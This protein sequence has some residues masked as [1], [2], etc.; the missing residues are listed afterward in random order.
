[1]F[2]FVNCLIKG[3]QAIVS[4][5]LISGVFG[6][7]KIFEDDFSNQDEFNKDLLEKFLKEK[8]LNLSSEIQ[9]LKLLP[10]LKFFS[11]QKD[12][13]YE[14]NDKNYFFDCEGMIMLPGGIDPHVHFD[15]PGYD[16]REDFSTASA[17][18]IAGGITTIID[19]P[20]TSIPPVTT[21]KNFY[22]KLNV[23]EKL[24]YSDYGFF[25]G[26]SGKTIDEEDF[27]ENIYDLVDCNVKGFKAYLISGMDSFPRLTNYQLYKAANICKKF[28]K[29]L[30]IHAEDFEFIDGYYKENIKY[31]QQDKKK[32]WQKEIEFY[33]NSRST[34]AELLA[35][36]T[37][38]EIAK[39]TGVRLH[40]V[41]LSSGESVEFIEKER[42]NC[43]ITFETAPHYLEFT[44]DDFIRFGSLLKTAPA[45]KKQQ[46]KN[47][48]R[49]SI[50]NGS[51]SFV[52]SDHAACN[53]EEK[54]SGSFL[55]DYS[56]I[57]GVQTIY[58]YILSEFYDTLS[59]ERIIEI[60]SENA[61]KFYNLYPKKGVIKKGSDADFILVK[62]DERFVFDQNNLYSKMKFSP[63]HNFEF[64]HKIVATVLRARPAY[65]DGIGIKLQKGD[66]KYI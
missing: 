58:Q 8:S 64:K 56:G 7:I 46:D 3:K 5:D 51:C 26:I 6:E 54:R 45:V 60:M 55:K 35:I 62:K 66:G 40:I 19:M 33:I 41:H 42:K 9:D 50:K 32:D 63:F 38:C 48:L 24:S 44:E 65:Y 18:A 22:E 2:Y 1:M 52:A 16:F 25:G 34:L 49:E 30:L 10:I 43:N 59:E 20:C 37:A 11:A 47:S 21:R 4:F 23:V 12:L 15:T 29:P 28:D 27:E 31:L 53:I 14:Y 36:Q 39:K 57:A 17:S 13:L 61:A